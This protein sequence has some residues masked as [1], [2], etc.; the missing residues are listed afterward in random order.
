MMRRRFD[1]IVQG[2]ATGPNP[3][4]DIDLVQGGPIAVVPSLGSL[5][6][7]WLLAIP[8]KKLLSLRELGEVER[9]D[10]LTFCEA[11][12]QSLS[13]FSSQVYYLEHGPAF[14]QS[15]VGCG[16]DQAHLHLVPTSQPLLE[17]VLNDDGV[18]WVET[19]RTDPWAGVPAGVEYYLISCSSSA[20]SYVGLPR[21]PQSQYF[22]RN[23]AA[24]TGRPDEW[25]YREWPHYE[26]IQRT[27]DHFTADPAVQAA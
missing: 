27:I 17:S 9:G 5:F 13:R 25:D 8:R 6:P 7:G 22:R 20:K 19:S 12:G 24:L 3:R 10:F 18:D 4:C 2:R 16:L 11:V 14:E 1:W 23:L 26:H 21:E 15:K